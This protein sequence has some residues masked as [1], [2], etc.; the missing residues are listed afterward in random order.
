M[1]NLEKIRNRSLDETARY[2]YSHDDNLCDEICESHGECPFG[3]NVETHNCI[4]CIK[5]W[6]KEEVKQ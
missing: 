2:I 1:T 5:Q 3:D 6:L 4:D